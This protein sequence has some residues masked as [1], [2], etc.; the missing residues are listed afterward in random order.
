MGKLLLLDSLLQEITLTM[1]NATVAGGSF[2]NG[3]LKVD[4]MGASRMG[5]RVNSRGDIDMGDRGICEMTETM[6]ESQF[7]H[8]DQNNFNNETQKTCY[9]KY[10]S[11]IYLTA[12][13]IIIL[14]FLLMI[15][16]VGSGGLNI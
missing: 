1:F 15:I 16:Y 12:V 9:E 3:Y 5:S 14:L 6:L 4:M 8:S 2:S 13:S 11:C 7:C 10:K